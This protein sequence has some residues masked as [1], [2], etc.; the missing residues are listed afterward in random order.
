MR[1]FSPKPLTSKIYKNRSTVPH[2]PQLPRYFNSPTV[3]KDTDTET[4]TYDCNT[5][6]SDSI[7]YYNEKD[8]N[9]RQCYDDTVI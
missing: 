3:I 6:D 5:Y 2:H 9:C 1:H 8:Y 4:N 7:I